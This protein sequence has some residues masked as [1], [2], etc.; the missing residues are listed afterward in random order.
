[1]KKHKF[2]PQQLSISE[3]YSCGSESSR[4]FRENNEYDCDW[5]RLKGEITKSNIFLQSFLNRFRFVSAFC[6]AMPGVL[7]S[8]TKY[9]QKINDFYYIKSGDD[10]LKPDLN[11][12]P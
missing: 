1:M 9:F 8:E 2:S 7:S 11:R 12:V 5:S 10:C 4:R 3:L 6:V